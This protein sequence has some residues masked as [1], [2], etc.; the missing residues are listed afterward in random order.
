M[1]GKTAVLIVSTGL[2]AC[3]LLAARQMRTQAAHELARSRLRAAQIDNDLARLRAKIASD[4]S[5]ERV[6]Q[7]AA[8]LDTLKPLAGEFGPRP[9]S[10]NTRI[11]RGSTG[12]QERR[13]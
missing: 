4:I 10:D 8:K 7:M 1:F 5:P 11:A 12:E 2:C 6:M 9:A 13:R 3:G